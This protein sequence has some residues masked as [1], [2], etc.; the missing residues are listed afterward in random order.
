MAKVQDPMMAPPIVQW[1]LLLLLPQF[2]QAPHQLMLVIYPGSSYANSGGKASKILLQQNCSTYLQQTVAQNP[3]KTALAYDCNE[4][5]FLLGS[6]Q[7]PSYRMTSL[8]KSE[9]LE[10]LFYPQ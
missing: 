2:G 1:S 10:S 8:A 6:T 9:S 7:P 4:G 5:G 3:S